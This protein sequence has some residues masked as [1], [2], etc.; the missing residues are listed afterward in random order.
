MPPGQERSLHS[1]TMLTWTDEEGKWL[2]E[3]G[4]HC[5]EVAVGLTAVMVV[6]GEGEVTCIRTI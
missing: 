3:E 4:G 2:G 5:L 6:G 1:Q